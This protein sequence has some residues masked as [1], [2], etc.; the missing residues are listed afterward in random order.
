MLN[1][2]ITRTEPIYDQLYRYATPSR[3]QQRSLYAQAG[4]IEC[5][6]VGLDINLD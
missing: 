5:K 3:V 2:V 1:R 6:D 4:G